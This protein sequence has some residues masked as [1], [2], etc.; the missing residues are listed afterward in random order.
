MLRGGPGLR[1]VR[2]VWACARRGPGLPDGACRA[3]ARWRPVVVPGRAKVWKAGM[4]PSRFGLVRR[5]L[6]EHVADE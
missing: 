2:A 3:S 4:L 5:H 1:R 6:L